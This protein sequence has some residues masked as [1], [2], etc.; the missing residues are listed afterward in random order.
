MDSTR[1][2]ILF[3][4]QYFQFSPYL[5]I[6]LIFFKEK[7]VKVCLFDPGLENNNGNPSA[8]LGDLIIQEA[9]TRELQNL[10][11]QLDLLRITTH[12]LP[13]DAKIIEARNCQFAFVGGTNLLSS[14]M[15]KGRQWKFSLKQ[16]I[17]LNKS[18]IKPTL[19]GVGWRTYQNEPPDFYSRVILKTLLSNKIIHSVRDNYTKNKLNSAGIKNVLN[20][21]CPTMWPF[22]EF[23][24][25]EIPQTKAENALVMLT[26]YSPNPELDRKLLELVANKYE[27]I[28]VWPQG[29]GD[30]QYILNIAADI[31]INMTMLEHSYESFK[32]LLKSGI[33]FD[34]IGT[35]LHGGI[36]C[37][38]SKK[39]SLIVAIDNR[40]K[41]IA[42]DTNLPTCERDDFYRITQWIETASKVEIK[43]P[44]DAIDKW[45]SQFSKFTKD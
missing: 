27:T 23:N 19:L 35:R 21:G 24:Y 10:F 18:L 2:V 30:K 7:I 42:K 20:T 9:V 28:F 45:K 43:M 39:R 31:P 22:T 5:Y 34:Y 12:S 44:Q 25:D 11:P 36:K 26:D 14:Q 16:Q 38:L 32:D 1:I 40:G 4:L 13:T 3:Y 15:G 8:N 41:E 29:R 6:H 37:L 33:A 17:L